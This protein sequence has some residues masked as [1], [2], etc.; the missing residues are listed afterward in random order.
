MNNRKL[1]LSTL[2]LALCLSNTVLADEASPSVQTKVLNGQNASA[3]A[4]NLLPWQAAILTK[5]N[6]RDNVISGCGAVIISEHWV[7]TAAHCA[8]AAANLSDT[9][10]AG[11]TYIPQGKNKDLTAEYQFTIE[12][13]ILHEG[14][15]ASTSGTKSINAG[16]VDHDIALMRVQES[17]ITVGKPIK[18]ATAEEQN[19]ANTQFI[20]TWN[21]TGY[22]IG[23][24]I[25]SGWGD[26]A[27]SFKPS[28]ELQV[29]KLGGIPMSQCNSSYVTTSNSHFVCAD[30]NNPA[31]KKDVCAGDS[32]GPLIWQNPNKAGDA[33]LGLRVI[34]VT[35]NGPNCRFKNAGYLA[36]QSNGLYTELASYR[37]WIETKTGLTLDNIATSDFSH[38]PFKVVREDEHVS[39]GGSSGGS[40][41]LAALLGLV[42][43]GLLRRRC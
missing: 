30:S 26:V 2:F 29:V 40:V 43:T 36:S 1:T 14:Y 10:V 25:A 42:L 12:Q 3:L 9:L 13:K 19:Q 32:G 28:N 21:A 24:L 34:G 18:I 37:D 20:N 15:K 7:V 16:D 11:L 6:F 23:N 39:T 22:S 41:P 31:I 27:P 4:E 5:P 17:L 8:E 33:D 35:S 38:D